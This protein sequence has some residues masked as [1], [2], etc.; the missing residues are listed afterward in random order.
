MSQS[1][2]SLGFLFQNSLWELST[3][4]GYKDIH[5][6]VCEECKKSVIIQTGHSSD[7]VSWVE[8]VASLSRELIAWLDYTF[9]PVVLQLSW[10]FSSLHTSHVCHFGDLLVARLL[11]MHASWVFFALSH[12]QTLHNSLL[13][14]GYLIAKIQAN[15]AQNK[16]NTWLN[17]F[18]LT[19]IYI[20][21]H[22]HT[23]TYIYACHL[24]FLI[25][26]HIW[27]NTR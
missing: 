27:P 14:T 12:T 25:I 7:S 1:C 5:S 8:R 6:G 10:P 24:L 4:R 23:H 19:V 13:N 15:S 3:F 11:C 2:F 22:I 16:A 18:N 21:T 17:K 9:C 26:E 20:Y